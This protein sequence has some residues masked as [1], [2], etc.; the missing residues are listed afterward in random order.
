MTLQELRAQFDALVEKQQALIDSE[1]TEDMSEEDL[2]SAIEAGNKKIQAVRKKLDSRLELNAHQ[3]FSSGLS[4]SRGR[5]TTP[6]KPGSTVSIGS[7]NATD[8]TM[9]VPGEED[10]TF[11]F[12]SM[13]EFGRAV[14]SAGSGGHSAEEKLVVCQKAM[15]SRFMAASV[16]NAH[17]EGASAEGEGYYVPTAHRNQIVEAFNGEDGL[18]KEVETEPVSTNNVEFLRDE[19]TPWGS[20]GVIARFIGENIQFSASKMEQEASRL[21][22]H[23]LYVFALATEEL[24]AD[25]QRLTN[26]LGPKTGQAMAWKLGEKIVRGTGV[27][28]PQGWTHANGP[29]ITVAKESGQA[30]DTIVTANVLKMYARQLDIANAIW[31]INKN[32]IPQLAVMTIGNQPIYVPPSGLKDAPFGS[33]LGR[34]IRYSDHAETLG[35]KTDIMFVSPKGYY[36]P[37]RTGGPQ[38]AQSMHLYFDYDVRAFRTTWRIGGSPFLT[39]PLTPA[40]GDTQSHFVTLAERA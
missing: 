15:H 36:S 13:G 12:L 11:G 30:A 28:E 14:H 23:K 10:G 7:P 8:V 18:H 1:V 21:W 31:Y 33:L 25:A 34:P 32:I 24:L 22:L 6:S 19:T 29:L 40:Y 5:I 38:E 35:N 9:N 17:V 16:S 3:E 37:R 27:N 20:A 4:A 39:Q 2:A 26:R